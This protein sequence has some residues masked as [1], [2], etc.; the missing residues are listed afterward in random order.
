MA[1]HER[2][3]GWLTPAWFETLR[4]RMA[5]ECRR[6]GVAIPAMVAMPDHLH[7]LIAG[8]NRASDQRLFVRALRRFI[9]GSLPAG[10]RLQKQA[11]DHV[12]RESETGRDGFA[13][14]VHY[15]VENPVRKELI[16]AADEWPYMVSCVPGLDR[17]HPADADFGDRWWTWWRQTVGEASS[18]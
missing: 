6:S 12:L 2:A 15:V 5:R 9:N 16:A 7:F 10:I 14:L 18:G 1:M 11:Y 4:E 8:V 13:A 3:T 17:L